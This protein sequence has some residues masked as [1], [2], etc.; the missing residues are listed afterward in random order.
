VRFDR[1]KFIA[2]DVEAL[3]GFYE[4]ALD[5]ETVVPTR[6]ITDGVVARA[7]GVPGA[8]LKL[9][10]LRL[11]GRGEHGPVLE[12]YSVSGG[13]PVPDWHYVPGQGQLAFE[14]EDLESS[15]RRVIAA[16]GSSLGEVVRWQAPSGAEARFVYLRDPE[17]NIIDLWTKA[18]PA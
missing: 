5:C 7:V 2:R 13:E 1:A 17:D 12:I 14:V 15:I 18:D 6:D 9:T 10:V 16:G 11:P 4:E 8:D 3:A